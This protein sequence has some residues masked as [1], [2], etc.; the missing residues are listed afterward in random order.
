M[1]PSIFHERP[2]IALFAFV[3]EHPAWILFPQHGG[4]LPAFFRADK[5]VYERAPAL[6]Q[7]A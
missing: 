4:E 7:S 6:T 2:Q 1:A 5:D 3:A